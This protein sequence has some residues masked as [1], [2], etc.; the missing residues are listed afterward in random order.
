MFIILALF[1]SSTIASFIQ[2]VS[3]FGFGICIMTILPI[4]LQ[5]KYGEATTLSGMLALTQSFYVACKLR[6]YIVWKRVLPMLG[7]FL[8][9]SY[10]CIG[11]IAKFENRMLMHILGV[12]LILLSLY[13]L[14][15]SSKIKIRQSVPMQMGLGVV[16]GVL[17]GF[18]GMQGPPAVLYYVQT[19][20]DKY[21]YAAQTQVFFVSGNVFMT[22]IRAQ[23]GYLTMDVCKSWLI[24]IV[25]VIIGTIVGTYVFDKISSDKLKKVIYGYMIIS[26]IVF[27]CK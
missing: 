15:F 8:V 11:C 21:Y 7:V 18:F 20:P 19:E 1:F 6:K 17:G 13:F 9:I 24:A 10:V 4:L 25:G 14:F 23:N 5:G 2:R 22:C 12:T 3:G 16:S 26:G 27:I